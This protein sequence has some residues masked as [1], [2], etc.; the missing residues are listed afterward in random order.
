MFLV[1][2]I[3]DYLILCNEGLHTGRWQ[4]RGRVGFVAE[5]LLLLASERQGAQGRHGVYRFA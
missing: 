2:E 4:S 3:R 5:N 1:V